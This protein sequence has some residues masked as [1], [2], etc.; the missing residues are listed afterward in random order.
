[1][2]GGVAAAVITAVLLTSGGGEGNSASTVT[3]A[4]SST[5]ASLTPTKST[6]LVAQPTSAATE[7][8]DALKRHFT[9]IINHE[10]PAAWRDLTGRAK[11]KG[12]SK[13]AWIGEQKAAGLEHFNLEVAPQLKQHLKAV[14]PI[15]YFT[16][17]ETGSCKEWEGSWSLVKSDGRWYISRAEPKV[18]A[19]C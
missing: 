18:R 7:I 16:T 14:A 15:V 4:R 11:E 3:N 8:S 13:A 12:V 2:L 5:Q 10:Y 19:E 9:E 17:T 6:P 1:M